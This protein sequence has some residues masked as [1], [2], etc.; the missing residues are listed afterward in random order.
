[1]ASQPAGVG[2]FASWD[3]DATEVVIID[4]SVRVASLDDIVRSKEAAGR[5]KDKLQLP[6]L[7][8]LRDRLRRG[9]P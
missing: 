4:L 2:D 7:R 5:D 6:V 8:A 9:K 3:A 1:V